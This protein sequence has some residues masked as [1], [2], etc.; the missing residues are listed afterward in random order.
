MLALAVYVNPFGDFGDVGITRHLRSRPV[1]MSHLESLPDDKLPQV[2]VFG[3]SNT[4]PMK[5]ET[6]QRELG[7]TA[8]NMGVFWGK[9]EDYLCLL[10]WLVNDRGHVPELA[11]VGLDTWT[12]APAEDDHPIF[13]GLT[14]ELLNT[15][16][17]IKYHP[18]VSL[19]PAW[20]SR[21][22]DSFSLGIIKEY[23]RLARGKLNGERVV[24]E[25]WPTLTGS[26]LFRADG[27]RVVYGDLYN[28]FP[29][30][31]FQRVEDGQYPISQIIQEKIDSGHV[32][33]LQHFQ[34]YS[35]TQFR[36]RRIDYLD[37][38]LALA[39]K[40]GVRV[41]FVLNPVHPLFWKVLKEHTSHEQNV[42]KLLSVIKEM[43]KKHSAVIGVVDASHIEYFGGDPTGFYDEIHP[44]TK[45]AD[46]ILKKVGEVVRA[47][48]AA[49]RVVAEDQ[50]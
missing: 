16:D 39:T 45:N 22:I 4:M 34:G 8:F 21:I 13:P 2:V 37:A 46:L 44:T 32:E 20:W 43:R 24:R 9:S 40:R 18:D 15:P 17:L 35:F 7:K 36:Q 26:K 47:A 11:I 23:Y 49:P 48:P 12:I 5:P 38:F 14:R 19:I 31:I 33:E 41:V 50:P 10:S 28:R 30:N 3:S 1:K 6:I 42:A 25:H 27:V 29:G